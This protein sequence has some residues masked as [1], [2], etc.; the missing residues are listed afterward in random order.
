MRS[1]ISVLELVV[2]SALA[3]LTYWVLLGPVVWR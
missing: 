2:G 1:A 3:V